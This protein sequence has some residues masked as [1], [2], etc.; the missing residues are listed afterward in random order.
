[1]QERLTLPT[2]QGINTYAAWAAMHFACTMSEAAPQACRAR[3]RVKGE[4]KSST[5][6][7]KKVTLRSPSLCTL[8]LATSRLRCLASSSTNCTWGKSRA[9]GML[10]CP[11]PQQKSTT[12]G[13]AGAGEDKGEGVD[14]GAVGAVGEGAKVGLGAEVGA[15]VGAEVGGCRKGMARHMMLAS[16]CLLRTTRTSGRPPPLPPSARMS[17]SAGML[18]QSNAC[19][20]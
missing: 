12:T 20:A 15:V 13:G 1:M 3:P 10:W 7:R 8:A 18:S 16:C 5:K 14:V 4:A 11:Q 19:A 2:Q 9:S 6:P 17:A